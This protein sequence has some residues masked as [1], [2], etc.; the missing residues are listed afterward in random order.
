MSAGSRPVFSVNLS[1]G[2]YSH[3][4]PIAAQLV[5]RPGVAKPLCEGFSP[6]A[7][8]CQ[9]PLP[10]VIGRRNGRVSRR[11]GVRLQVRQAAHCGKQQDCT[12]PLWSNPAPFHC[13]QLALI[14]R[15]FAAV[16]GG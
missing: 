10:A 16:R 2:S 15:L 6:V 5:Q 7:G 3:A 9:H 4:Y 14:Q 8:M 12:M 13:D 11:R 1:N